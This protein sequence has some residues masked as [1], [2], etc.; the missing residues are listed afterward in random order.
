MFGSKSRKAMIKLFAL[1]SVGLDLILDE[2]T[3]QLK[4]DGVF[5]EYKQR[6][7]DLKIV[8]NTFLI[9]NAMEDDFKMRYRY[10]NLSDCLAM[11]KEIEVI[12]LIIVS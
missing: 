4:R 12:L 3:K 10:M 6:C 1:F 5:S 8:P 11:A 2:K 9:R 7:R